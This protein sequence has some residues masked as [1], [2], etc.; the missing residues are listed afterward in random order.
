MHSLTRQGWLA[1]ASVALSFACI[2]P[3]TAGGARSVWTVGCQHPIVTGVEIYGL[4]HILNRPRL[5]RR[6]RIL[7]LGEIDG[8][9]QPLALPLPQGSA[10]AIPHPHLRLR[11]FRGWRLSTD[12]RIRHV[13]RHSA[14]QCDRRQRLSDRLSLRGAHT[15]AGR[16][17]SRE[18][19]ALPGK[20]SSA[21]K[22]R[23]AGNVLTDSHFECP[24]QGDPFAGELRR[25][26]QSRRPGSNRKPPVYK[27]GALPIELRRQGP[28]MGVPPGAPGHR[29]TRRSISWR[30]VAERFGHSGSYANTS[31]SGAELRARGSPDKLVNLSP[32]PAFEAAIGHRPWFLSALTNLLACHIL[33]L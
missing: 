23:S 17:S 27:T 3:A 8:R 2:A 13:S 14:S 4:H 7:S 19:G 32:A 33:S 11:D 6:A 10:S 20:G 30:R 29:A 18:R 22:R 25:L 15:R 12:S 21:E 31:T 5:S 28:G 9:H 24:L 26:T 16:C 1:V